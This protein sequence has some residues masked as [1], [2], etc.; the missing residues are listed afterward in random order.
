LPLL[1]FERKKVLRHRAKNHFTT[2]FSKI[3][4]HTTTRI[5]SAAKQA[6]NT[7]QMSTYT[8]N[9]HMSLWL[10]TKPK[11]EYPPLDGDKKYDV[12]SK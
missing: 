9:K 4:K 8:F 2:M 3:L 7:A 10:G 1:I 12:A 6:S 11:K 5:V